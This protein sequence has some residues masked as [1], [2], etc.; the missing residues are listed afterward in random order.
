[1]RQ[2]RC[3]DAAQRSR[4]RVTSDAVSRVTEL[5]MEQIIQTRGGSMRVSE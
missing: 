5:C 2:S 3:T 4:E 1:V